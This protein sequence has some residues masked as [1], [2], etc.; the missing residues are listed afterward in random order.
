MQFTPQQIQGGIKFTSSTKIGNWFEDIALENAKKNIFIENAAIGGLTLRKQE[1]KIAKLNELVE[2]RN[3]GDGMI[4][5]GDTIILQHVSNNDKTAVLACDPYQKVMQSLDYFTVSGA[6]TDSI[7]PKARNTFRIIRA[8]QDN[9]EDSEDDIVKFGQPFCIACHESL[10]IDNENLSGNLLYLSSIR[11][12]ERIATKS[13]NRQLVF[14]SNTSSQDAV[15][16]FNTSS[17]G[18]ING[19]ERFLQFG[20]PANFNEPL[21]ITH[22][23]TNMNLSLYYEFCYQSDFGLEVECCADRRTTPG[24]LGLI[25]SEYLG[26]STTNTLSK[27][28]LNCYNWSIKT[29]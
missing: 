14:M 1:I 21:E 24:K 2:T 17:L 12:N 7:A 29:G 18:K 16:F 5:F 25:Q 13:S 4:R 19:A 23:Q 11:K 8:P 22:R 20:Y 26:K 28:E 10:C 15:W 9:S 3:S 27:A 6:L